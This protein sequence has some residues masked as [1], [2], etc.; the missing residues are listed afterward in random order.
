MLRRMPAAD[1]SR[2][3]GRVMPTTPPLEAEYDA[4]PI[5]PSNA[6]TLAR[7][8]IAPRQPSSS[9]SLWLIAVAAWRTMSKVPIRLIWMTLVK[10]PRSCADSIVP[11]RPMVRWA[12]PMP[13]ELTT[14]ADRRDLGGGLDRGADLLGVGDV[15][16]GE[17]A[18]DLLGERLA[19]VGLQVGH[20]HGG[21]A[22]GELTGDGGADARCAAGDDGR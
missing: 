2:A 10:A 7:L 20:H 17:H 18:L 8:T 11:S 6:A 5:C 13:A 3:T 16:L 4:W 15:D 9:G 21:T 1:R 22:G 19:L 14:V 12:Q